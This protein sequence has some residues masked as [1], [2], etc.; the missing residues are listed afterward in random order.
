MRTHRLHLGAWHEDDLEGYEALVSER[1][2]RTAAAPHQGMPSRDDLRGR[3]VRHRAAISDTG[4]GLLAVRI[5]DQ[6]AGY[7]GLVVGRASLDEPELAFELLA[8]YHGVGYATE[9]ARAVVDAAQG[10]GRR[11]LWATLRNWNDAS[12]R[13]LDKLGFERIEPTTTDEFGDVVWCTLRF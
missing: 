11:R 12:F 9:A 4:I 7:C 5:A 3:I 2:R 13:V 10:T 6:F 8:T 1:D